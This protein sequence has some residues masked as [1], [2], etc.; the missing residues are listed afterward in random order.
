MGEYAA[1]LLAGLAAVDVRIVGDLADLDPA[2]PDDED[3][4]PETGM[5]HELA[6][7]LADRL[8]SGFPD[9]GSNLTRPAQECVQGWGERP[10]R[11]ID[12]GGPA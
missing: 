2:H 7:R 11:L 10:D 9:V 1:T 4:P 5:I 3:A 12:Q 8:P 6:D